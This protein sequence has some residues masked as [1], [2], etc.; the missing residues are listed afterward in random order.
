[1]H[2]SFP[3]D[4]FEHVYLVDL[5]PSLCQVAQKRFAE[6]GWTNVT[7]LCQDASSF[8]ASYSLEGRVQLVTMSY[9]CKSIPAID[10]WAL[11]LFFFF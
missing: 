10:C 2:L 9:S 8:Q 5:T 1:M 11:I 6:R 3:V 4:Q 7:V